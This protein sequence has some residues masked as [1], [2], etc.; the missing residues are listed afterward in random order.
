MRLHAGVAREPSRIVREDMRSGEAIAVAIAARS[1]PSCVTL[2]AT[3]GGSSGAGRA[4]PRAPRGPHAAQSR[5]LRGQQ[6]RAR[7][8]R[9]R[10][11]D[12]PRRHRRAAV[13]LVLDVG[14][15]RRSRVRRRRSSAT[16]SSASS[17][18][19]SGSRRSTPRA[20]SRLDPDDL[21][22]AH[23]G[24]RPVPPGDARQP[25]R[26]PRASRCSRPFEVGDWI[27][28]AREHKTSRQGPRDQLARDEGAHAR[29]GRGHRPERAR[30]ARRPSRT[31]PS[32]SPRIRRS[33]YVT[34]PARR[35]P[36]PPG[37]AIARGA[38]RVVR[39]ARRSRRRRCVTNDFVD[40][41]RR[42]LGA[43]L[44]RPVPEAGRGRRRRR[45][46]GSGTRSRAR[47]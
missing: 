39:R 32:P 31:T 18:C 6:R 35:P 26:G 33:L 44:D 45:A 29:R 17:T 2:P 30:S 9:H 1:S 8:H 20:S 38:H 14:Y 10:G 11:R 7:A 47:A 43:L 24:H 25:L 19:S 36:R 16:S 21:G 13:A 12:D 41:E 42:V 40:G 3:A 46:T 15:G 34:I 22:A 23:G 27:Q 37:A 28:F 4:A 5:L